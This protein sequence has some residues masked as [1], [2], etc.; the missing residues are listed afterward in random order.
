MRLTYYRHGNR[1]ENKIALTFDDGP[2]PFWTRKILDILDKYGVKATFF[3][4]G[5]L[6]EK[7]K[8][9]VK[10]IFKRGH[11]IGNHG[12]SHSRN[13]RDFEK[14]EEIIFDIISMHTQFI[15]PPYLLV[16]L[17]SNYLPVIKGGVK[18]INCDVFPC[19]YKN[20]SEDII[21]TIN[22]K[23]KNGSIIILHDGSHREEELKNRPSEMFKALPILIKTLKKDF[24]LVKIDEL[25][26]VPAIKVIK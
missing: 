6:A 8:D 26:L 1:L 17:C 16:S 4:L 20:K 25:S 21:R 11:L 22:T 7:Y 10:E 23:T 9:I 18:I 5:K 12:Y 19:D 15:R 14:A 2:N 13:F 3:V 24:T